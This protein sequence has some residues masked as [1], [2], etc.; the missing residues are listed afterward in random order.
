M[1]NDGRVM[2]V[3]VPGKEGGSRAPNTGCGSFLWGQM[4]TWDVKAL[5][6]QRPVSS[7]EIFPTK[8]GDGSDV[9]S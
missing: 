9:G 3:R 2:S 6:G 1:F 7:S 5:R 4:D 8:R